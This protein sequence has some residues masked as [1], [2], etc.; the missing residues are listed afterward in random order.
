M[1]QSN[2]VKDFLMKATRFMNTREIAFL[3]NTQNWRV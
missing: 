2:Q 3:I 1:G